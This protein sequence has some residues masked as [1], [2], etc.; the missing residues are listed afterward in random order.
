[1]LH[2]QPFTFNPFSENTYLVWDDSLACVVIDP[3][4]A[5][6]SEQQAL[7]QFMAAQNLKLE[8]VLN[9]HCHIDHVFGNR[10]LVD[11][12]KVPLAAHRKDLMNLNGAVPYA[13]MMG[14]SFDPSP[15]P[16]IWLD[17]MKEISF[18]QTTFEIRFTPGHAPGHVSFYHAAS[19]TLFSG[20]VLFQGSIGRTDLPGGNF[21]TLMQSIAQQILTLPDETV[22]WSGHGPETTVGE[23]R[24]HNPFILE[25][26]N[27][28]IQGR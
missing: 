14:M 28:G 12:Y 24:Q 23:E 10:W 26:I 27:E 8:L 3:G 2:I 5:D 21:S 9:T 13:H 18:G 11:T 7:A 22:V 1:M 17:G 16:T 15:E 19:G 20:D 25:H 6:R 4:C